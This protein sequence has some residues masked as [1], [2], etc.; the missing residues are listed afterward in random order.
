MAEVTPVALIAMLQSVPHR[1]G[2]GTWNGADCWGIVE[3]WYRERFGI[4]LDDR[5]DIPPGPE[6]L[7]IGFD[8]K[9]HWSPVREPRDDDLVVMRTG[10]ID[11]GHVGVFF[12]GSVIHSEERS[13]CVCVPLKSKLV[14]SRVTGFLRHRQCM[15]I[16]TGS[17]SN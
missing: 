4:E 2:Q 1:K 10:R 9:V 15:T 13:G 11:A 3:L 12:G 7:Q 6:G 5:R 8:G 16:P 14:A 17:R